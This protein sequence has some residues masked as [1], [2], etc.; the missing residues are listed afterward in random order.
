[1]KNSE[2]ELSD[3]GRPVS[4]EY[5]AIIRKIACAI[6]SDIAPKSLCFDCFA[7]HSSLISSE[8][9]ENLLSLAEGKKVSTLTTGGLSNLHCGHLIILLLRLPMNFVNLGKLRPV[10][11]LTIGHRAQSLP[12][13]DAELAFSK[14]L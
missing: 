4:L 6:V 12:P 2:L 3:Q 5:E 14:R 11:F 10:K 13:T 8:I 7:R 9:D 1:M